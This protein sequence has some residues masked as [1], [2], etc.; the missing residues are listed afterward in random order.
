MSLFPAENSFL[1]FTVLT[2]LP[3]SYH[4]QL[5]VWCNVNVFQLILGLALTLAYREQGLCMSDC[6]LIWNV[7]VL[8]SNCQK[9]C[10]SILDD[11][12]A[13]ATFIF[14]T[15]KFQSHIE[16]VIDFHE[17]YGIVATEIKVNHKSRIYFTFFCLHKEAAV[18][19]WKYFHKT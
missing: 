2:F 13:A 11:L 6:L 14:I 18:F 3:T 17:P 16:K 19:I 4:L 8:T 1:K 10:I 7:S 12:S 9:S 5:L 15:L